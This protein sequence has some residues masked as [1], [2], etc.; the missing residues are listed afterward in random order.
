MHFSLTVV[1]QLL[2][3]AVGIATVRLL[4]DY[5]YGL[6][7]LLLG[8]TYAIADLADSGS[9]VHLLSLPEEDLATSATAAQHLAACQRIRRRIQIIA[10]LL[11]APLYIWLMVPQ[12]GATLAVTLFPLLIV[13]STSIGASG[14]CLALLRLNSQ[15][16]TAGLVQIGATTVRLVGLL[17]LH[18]AGVN[19]VRSC[20]ALYA[21]GSASEWAMSQ[22]ALRYPRSNSSGPAYRQALGSIR[23]R[24]L[25]VLPSSIYFAIVGQIIP[26]CVAALGSPEVLGQV[27]ALGR[28]NA[29]YLMAA[30]VMVPSL[31][32]VVRSGVG[33]GRF[34]GHRRGMLRYF[35]VALAGFLMSILLAP[36]LLAL[37][38]LRGSEGMLVA[39]CVVSFTGLTQGVLQVLRSLN[40]ARGWV[41]RTWIGIPI[42]VVTILLILVLQPFHSASSAAVGFL[43]LNAAPLMSASAAALYGLRRERKT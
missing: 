2:M 24:L 18:S 43:A 13:Q 15:F 30:S 8:L 37:L 11:L 38:D 3:F 32:L 4:S 40:D 19:D 12:T 6:V 29:G 27:A 26:V 20:V 21:M 35:S 23:A 22:R 42:S 25:I 1:N 28:F 14:L 39:F 10:C 33:S 36:M 7:F 16:A 41:S 17:G 34:D 5:S 31:I 9:L